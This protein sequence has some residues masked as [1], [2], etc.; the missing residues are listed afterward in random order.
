MHRI[1]VRLIDSGITGTIEEGTL[2][3][4]RPVPDRPMATTYGM[5]SA[6][7]VFQRGDCIRRLYCVEQYDDN[8]SLLKFAVTLTDEVKKQL[9]VWHLDH[10]H[11]LHTHPIENGKSTDAHV[12]FAGKLEDM[13]NEILSAIKAGLTNAI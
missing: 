12:P 6:V 4:F 7:N 2:C 11:G 5:T 13:V 10:S 3:L 9:G 8:N 1:A